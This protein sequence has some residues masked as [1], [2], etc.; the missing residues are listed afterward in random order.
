MNPSPVQHVAQLLAQITD[1]HAILDIL[2]RLFDALA[3]LVME[4]LIV[5]LTKLLE[6]YHNG[7]EEP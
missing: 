7:D 5:E 1:P 6:R 3:P 4:A 2:D